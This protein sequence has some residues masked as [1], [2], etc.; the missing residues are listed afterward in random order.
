MIQLKKSTF[1]VSRICLMNDTEEVAM[2]PVNLDLVVNAIGADPENPAT[3]AP[4][5]I[6]LQIKNLDDLILSLTK[7]RLPTIEND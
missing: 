5:M 3:F 7:R 6:Y 4:D 1:L 2:I